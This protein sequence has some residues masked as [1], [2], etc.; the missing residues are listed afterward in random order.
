LLQG[1]REATVDERSFDLKQQYSFPLRT[2]IL[3]SLYKLCCV[4]RIGKLL[5]IGV[6]GKEKEKHS[7]D[8]REIAGEKE[9]ARL[10]QNRS[11]Q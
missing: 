5:E 7:L 9:R 8:L 3:L 10:L 1:E 4:S 6:P 11:V 2:S